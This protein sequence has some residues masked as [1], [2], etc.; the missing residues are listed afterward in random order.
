MLEIFEFALSEYL[1]LRY[2]FIDRIIIKPYSVGCPVG[3]EFNEINIW[4]K[5]K[6]GYTVD[7]LLNDYKEVKVEIISDVVLV[8]QLVNFSELTVTF[9]YFPPVLYGR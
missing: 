8:K 1:H 4:L 5:Y 7:N 6:D 3:Y 2:D 9:F